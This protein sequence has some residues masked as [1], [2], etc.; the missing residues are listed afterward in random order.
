MGHEHEHSASR[1]SSAVT[2]QGS[3][4]VGGRDRRQWLVRRGGAPSFPKI[5]SV[6]GRLRCIVVLRFME[7]REI[8]AKTMPRSR[9]VQ[10]DVMRRGSVTHRCVHRA[11]DFDSLQTVA[12]PG[13]P[14][15]R[16]QGPQVRARG[17]FRQ[18]RRQDG[19]VP[20]QRLLARVPPPE[21]QAQVFP[22]C[23]TPKG[24]GSTP[25]VVLVRFGASR[26]WGVRDKAQHQ[27]S[28]PWEVFGRRQ[29]GTCSDGEPACGRG[30]A[31]ERRA[32]S[33][34]WTY[35]QAGQH[36]LCGILLR[37]L[38][39]ASTCHDECVPKSTHG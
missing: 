13:T 3:T 1:S 26:K 22:S 24:Q 32:S 18:R 23:S 39:L 6:F 4:S 14:H 12:C 15:C 28:V 35:P 16:R 30:M 31:G 8:S 25:S 10:A 36:M 11:R 38:I 27:A 5:D 20:H 21:S 7:S 29:I 37:P 9:L 2:K 33:T 34:M 19:D 17:D